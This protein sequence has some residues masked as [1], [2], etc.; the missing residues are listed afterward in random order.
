MG[1]VTDDRFR[2]VEAVRYALKASQDPATIVGAMKNEL[3]TDDEIVAY[4]TAT[5]TD[6]NSNSNHQRDVFTRAVFFLPMNVIVR[7]WSDR[8][9]VKYVYWREN[10]TYDEALM[11]TEKCVKT[12]PRHVVIAAVLNWFFE[13]GTS[14][15]VTTRERTAEVLNATFDTLENEAHFFESIR[16]TS[17]LATGWSTDVWAVIVERNNL[18]EEIALPF[19]SLIDVINFPDVPVE[20]KAQI[21]TQKSTLGGDWDDNCKNI[22]EEIWNEIIPDENGESGLVTHFRVAE[23]IVAAANTKGVY[24]PEFRTKMITNLTRQLVKGGNLPTLALKY[25]FESIPLNEYSTNLPTR[26][27]N[28]LIVELSAQMA[29][30]G[31]GNRVAD[32]LTQTLSSDTRIT[33]DTLLQIGKFARFTASAEHNPN[34]VSPTVTAKV[35]TKL[36]TAWEK[37]TRFDRAVWVLNLSREARNVLL[38]LVPAV[39]RGDIVDVIAVE[40]VTHVDAKVRRTVATHGPAEHL[41]MLATDPSAVVREAAAKRVISVLM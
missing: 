16:A 31:S 33:Y 29:H 18:P 38:P 37:M 36:P 19:L 15:T 40:M 13:S 28:D 9:P 24:T 3:L 22:P 10:L 30:A 20:L 26:E 11:F 14:H 21:V 1:A 17:V 25:V 34:W 27:Y 7:M 39:T 6:H 23:K 2:T 8:L 4:F 41:Q 32:G 12:D 35:E 5:G